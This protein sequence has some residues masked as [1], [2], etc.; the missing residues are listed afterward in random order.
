MGAPRLQGGEDSREKTDGIELGE[1]YW[2]VREKTSVTS[3]LWVCR[4]RRATD[5]PACTHCP[6]MGHQLGG[7]GCVSQ[8][9]THVLMLFIAL[10]VSFNPP[11]WADCSRSAQ[12]PCTGTVPERQRQRHPVPS[13]REGAPDAPSL[14]KEMAPSPSESPAVG[15][16]KVLAPV[17]AFQ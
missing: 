4:R 7:Q 1:S 14:G 6:A 3:P 12:G 8:R 11:T 13:S 5:T 2:R 9:D 16:C 17:K 15:I 10:G